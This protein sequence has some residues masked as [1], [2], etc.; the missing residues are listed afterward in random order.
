MCKKIDYV[1]KFLYPVAI[2]FTPSGLTLCFGEEIVV[3][4]G[5]VFSVKSDGEIK[6]EISLEQHIAGINDDIASNQTTL[7]VTLTAKKK[8]TLLE[9]FY[10]DGEWENVDEIVV[11]K[12]NLSGIGAFIRKGSVSFMISLDF[13]YS[14]IRDGKNRVSIGCDP[15]DKIEKGK[16]YKIS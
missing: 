6:S 12:T 15:L 7:N 3:F 5:D 4:K 16:T 9:Y 13:P 10:F 1:N 14:E 11:N 8:C 2:D